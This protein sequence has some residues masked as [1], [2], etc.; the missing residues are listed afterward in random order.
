MNW[1]YYSLLG[2]AR[3]LELSEEREESEQT[4]ASHI[5][6]QKIASVK[7]KDSSLSSESKGLVSGKNFYKSYL[8]WVKKKKK[9]DFLIFICIK[10]HHIIY[11]IEHNWMNLWWW[12]LYLKIFYNTSKHF[13]LFWKR[14]SKNTSHKKRHFQGKR[15]DNYC[16]N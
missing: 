9:I 2:F 7:S 10:T 5:T 12:K 14:P 11:Q 16:Y 8:K 15:K 4:S 6:T 13:I 3:K 1:C